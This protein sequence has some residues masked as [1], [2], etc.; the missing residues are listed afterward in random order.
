MIALLLACTTGTDSAQTVDPLEWAIDAPGPYQVGVRMWQHSY[1]P[2]VGDDRTI[3]IN[4]WYPTDATSGAEVLYM[5]AFV[6]EHAILNAPLAPPVYDGTYP[7]HVHSHGFQGWGGSS[8]FLARHL[9]SHG[10]VVV[11]PDHTDNT[12]LD[13]SDPLPTSHYLTKN[14]DVSQALDALAADTE[15]AAADTSRVVMSGHSF[16]STSTWS[17]AGAD[18]VNMTEPASC[19]SLY[20]GRACTDDE[21]AAFQAGFRDDRVIASIP[22][23]GGVRSGF[24]GDT[25]Y[26]AVET[27]FLILTGSEDFPYA[28]EFAGLTGI[29]RTW[30]ELDGGCHQT[31]ATGAC[32]SLDTDEG[33]R[34]VNGYVMAFSRVH[35][36][37]DDTQAAVMDGSAPLGDAA[38]VTTGQ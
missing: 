2:T 23:A 12:L 20:E 27:P 16:G 6:D 29:E 28:D 11:A 9:A 33:F 15:L 18:Y 17:V 24:F 14:W 36:F 37:G 26:A 13:H 25:G 31:F 19:E 5:D 34:L 21:I 7:V 4:V 32:T 38:T 8:A 22:M 30:V 10:W 1:T 35:L 3:G